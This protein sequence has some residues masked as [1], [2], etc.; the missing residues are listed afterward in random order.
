MEAVIQTL[1]AGILLTVRHDGEMEYDIICDEV[2]QVWEFPNKFRLRASVRIGGE[3]RIVYSTD[4]FLPE[5]LTIE[6]HEKQLKVV[7]PWHLY[8]VQVPVYVRPEDRTVR[9]WTKA[10]ITTDEAFTKLV[11]LASFQLAGKNPK[12]EWVTDMEDLSMALGDREIYQ[13]MVV[14]VKQ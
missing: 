7:N 2:E 8:E 6:D 11:E 10:H 5:Q 14:E 3:M 1:G 12:L 13:R 4:H 9:V